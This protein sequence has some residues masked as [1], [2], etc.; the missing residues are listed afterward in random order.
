MMS[1]LKR[2]IQINFR[3]SAHEWELI[4]KKMALLG[5]RNMT[6]YMRKM[7]IDGQIVRL[8]VPELKEIVRLLRYSSNNLNQLA[9]RANETGAVYEVDIQGLRDS[10][11][12]IWDTINQILNG[13]AKL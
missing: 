8:E 2:S 3:V 1:N 12:S 13:L 10:Y 6:A 11:D 7:A 4:E 9:K 5:T